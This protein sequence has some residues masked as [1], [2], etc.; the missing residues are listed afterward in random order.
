MKLHIKATAWDRLW[1]V[2]F[3]DKLVS[4]WLTASYSLAQ[5]VSVY[6]ISYVIHA[7]HV[8]PL[9]RNQLKPYEANIEAI[10]AEHLI[11]T[12]EPQRL[13]DSQ[14]VSN[15]IIQ[16]LDF[17]HDRICRCLWFGAYKIHIYLLCT[18]SCILSRWMSYS[19]LVRTCICER[20]TGNPANSPLPLSTCSISM[21]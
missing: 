9:P 17:V 3:T 11:T 13:S 20:D 18:S 1:F 7:N 2:Q 12:R 16:Y 5:H 10:Y 19:Q 21:E 14:F 8:H 6:T 4:W 15:L